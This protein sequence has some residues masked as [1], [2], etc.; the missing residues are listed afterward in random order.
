MAMTAQ[1]D[2]ERDREHPRTPRP[3]RKR[4]GAPVPDQGAMVDEHGR[5]PGVPSRTGAD[6]APPPD[7]ERVREANERDD[8][9]R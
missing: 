7:P 3:D 1:D 6:G 5:R 9:Q 4:L 8:P 2:G